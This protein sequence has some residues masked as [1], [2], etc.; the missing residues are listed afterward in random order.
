M[1][2]VAPEVPE[3]ELARLARAGMRGVRFNFTRHLPGGADPQAV[4]ALAP[5]LAAHGLHLQVHFESARTPA[6]AG[7]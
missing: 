1:A 5:R 4:M 6:A 3:V 7:R 2:L